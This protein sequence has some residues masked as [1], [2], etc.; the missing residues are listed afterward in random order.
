MSALKH[1]KMLERV[2]IVIQIIFRELVGSLLVTEF[3]SFYT[4]LFKLWRLFVVMRQHNVWCVCVAT[5]THQTLC[6]RITTNNFHNL[7]KIIKTFKL[8]DFNKEPTSSLK[9]IWMTIE[10]RSS[11]LKCFNTDNL[12]LYITYL[13][14]N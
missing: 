9:M 8:S 12:D 2:S 3:K 13:F 1:L 10:T 4:F 5:H 6:C 14:I 7:K 11:I